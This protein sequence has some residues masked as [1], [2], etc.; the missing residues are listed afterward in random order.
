MARAEARAKLSKILPNSTYRQN[1]HTGGFIKQSKVCIF[2]YTRQKGRDIP[3]KTFFGCDTYRGGKKNK[4]GTY[5]TNREVFYPIIS[6]TQR[7]IYLLYKYR[8]QM[9]NNLKIMD[10]KIEKV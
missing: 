2:P 9:Q 4:K 6:T 3:A 7:D 1:I 10:L 5:F 8:S